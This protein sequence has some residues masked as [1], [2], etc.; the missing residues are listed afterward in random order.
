MKIIKWLAVILGLLAFVIAPSLPADS[1]SLRLDKD[2][3]FF[4]GN[5]EGAEA[6]S[7]DTAAW[8]TVSVPHTWNAGDWQA[9]AGYYRGPGWYRRTLELPPAWKG[10][11]VFLR[12]EAASIAADIFLNGQKVGGHKG[13]FA[14]FCVEIT[15]AARFDT[16]NLLAVRVS[17]AKDN[18]VPPLSGDFNMF[19][20]LY[21]PV[22]LFAHNQI[23]I[24]PLDYGAPGVAVRQAALS[25][26]RAG[27]KVTTKI[28]NGSP[29]SQSMEVVTRIQDAAG[30]TVTSAKLPVTVPRDETTA[31]EQSLTIFK[32]HLWNGLKDPYLYTVT[33]ELQSGGI[34]LDTAAQPLGLRSLRFDSTQGFF[35]ND[36]PYSIHGVNRHQDREGSGWALSE[37]EQD[38]DLRLIREM[39]ANSVRL[40][41]YQHSEYFYGL[42]DKAGLVV[43]AEIPLVNEVNPADDFAANARQQLTELIR[44]N[45][46]HPSIIVWSVYNE[47][48]LR[49]KVDP[50]LLVKNLH[51]LAKAEDTTRP[52]VGATSQGELTKYPEMVSTPDLRAGNL[53]PGWYSGEPAEMGKWI[54]QFNQNYGARGFGVS[55]YGAGASV[56]QHEQG[57]TQRPDPRGK[58]HP[59]EWQAIQHE[60]NYAAIV[61]R[62]FV[63]CSFIWNMFDFSSSGRTEGDRDGINDKGLLSYDRKTKKDAFFFYQANWSKEPMVYITSHRHIERSQEVTDV[64]AYSNGARAELRVNGKSYGSA[65]PNEVRVFIWKGVKLAPGENLIEVSAQ[66]T[67]KTVKDTCRWTYRPG[68][69]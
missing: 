11:R 45:I 20:G 22:S 57:M 21:R 67:G 12:F 27:I 36:Q 58:W 7:F 26:E 16:A 65:A 47:I 59:E 63:W 19:G 8:E 64:K 15:Q 62:P 51:E 46:N 43:W 55:E 40:A 48:G 32:P 23:C 34:V 66:A 35:L 44:Q 61:A 1:L 60:Q 50:T 69:F 54:D 3:R 49:T 68:K 53:Y 25:S 38:E 56:K 18:M 52:T 6:E 13:A 37:K 17:N 5:P 14:A 30:K 24:T 41:H 10:K 9:A 39:G 31:A 4:K 28:S 42:C 2:W 29:A 33:V